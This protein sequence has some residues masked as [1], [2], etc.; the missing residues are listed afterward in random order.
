MAR[1][2]TGAVAQAVLLRQ[3]ANTAAALYGAHKATGQAQRAREI[4]RVGKTELA[5]VQAA[6]TP[7]PQAPAQTGEH[8]PIPAGLDPEAAGTTTTA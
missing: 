2:G 7:R 8:P 6:L 3:R 1:G 5:M 4:L